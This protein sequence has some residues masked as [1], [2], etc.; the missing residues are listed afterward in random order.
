MSGIQISG[1]LANSAFDWKSVVDQLIAADS[2]PVT[3]LQK[4]QTTNSDQSSALDALKTQLTDL[5]T[6]ADALN[7][8][9]SG[10]FSSRLVM[11]DVANTTWKSNASAGAP[12][13]SYKI[14]VTRLATAAQ[15]TGV[16]DVGQGLS[17][18][19]NVSG[20]TLATL[21]T[22]TAITAG[23]FTVNGQQITIALTDSLQDVFDKIST[24]TGGDLTAQPP[25]HGDVTAA[26]DPSTDTVSLTSRSHAEVVL[27]AVNDTSNFL[28]AMRLGNNGTST[29]TSDS[30]LGTLKINSPLVTAGLRGAITAVDGSG[31]GTFTVNGVAI[32]YNINTDS[33]TSVLSRINSSNAGV[34]ARYDAANDRMVVANNTTGDVGLGLNETAGGLLGAL[35]LTTGA[36]LAH[37]KNAQ[38]SVNDGPTRTSTSN[39]L[40]SATLGISGLSVTVNTATTQ[41]VEVASDV[42]SMQS[43]IQSFIDKFNAVQ[44]TIDA[45]TKITSSSGKVTTSVLSNNRDV[46]DWASQLQSLAFGAVSGLT[47]TVARLSDLGIDFNSTT[48]QLAIKDSSKLAAA[49]TDRPDDVASFFRSPSTGFVAKMDSYLGKIIA[50]DDTQQQKLTKAN[51]DLDTQIATLQT[52]LD[53][54]RTQLTNS[55]I[56]MLDAQSQA[57]STSTYLT[58]TFFKSNTS[59]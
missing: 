38:F 12:V 33:I 31:K 46:Q 6:A 28:Q 30:A 52:R 39:T 37:G 21:P 13:G 25:T 55:F 17:A 23:T 36:T 59:S 27:G 18:T 45:D 48:G 3:N 10:L 26:Y 49:L 24:A 40:D 47:G 50:A 29:V 5:Q 9:N 14:N 1:L 34:T 54:E 22:A 58:N 2:I 57:Q 8:S 35:G 19:S 42:A 43:A 4:E 32:N 15:K 7:D 51:S 20:L 16:A 11:S 53:D 41:T 56:A 44:T